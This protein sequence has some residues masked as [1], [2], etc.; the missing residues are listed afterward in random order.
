MEL[1]EKSLKDFVKMVAEA[2]ED[3][4]IKMSA[5]STKLIWPGIKTL[6]EK[7]YA[8]T[9]NPFTA[10]YEHVNIRE[11][12]DTNEKA[13]EFADILQE[14]I[15]KLS[16]EYFVY[17]RNTCT[18]TQERD[19]NSYGDNWVVT[20]RFSIDTQRNTIGVGFVHGRTND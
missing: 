13:Q 20:S 9:S 10:E 2:T 18:V 14:V 19:F 1:T 11:F 15:E 8:V 4:G 6:W 7:E 17:I 16:T 12:F 5:A 3:R